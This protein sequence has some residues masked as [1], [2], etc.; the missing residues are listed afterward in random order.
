MFDDGCYPPYGSLTRSDHVGDL[1]SGQGGRRSF[2]RPEPFH[3]VRQ[4]IDEA[5]VLFNPSARTRTMVCETSLFRYFVRMISRR[6]GMPSN[7]REPF[8]TFGPELRLDQLPL[9]SLETGLA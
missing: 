1:R 4:A 3:Q 2:E 7:Q 5:V 8:T 6:I 9:R